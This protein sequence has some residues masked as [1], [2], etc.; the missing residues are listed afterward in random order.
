[1]PPLHTK[2]LNAFSR[3]IAAGIREENVTKIRLSTENY[4]ALLQSL[5]ITSSMIRD[6]SSA[7]KEY[8]GR[9]CVE[10]ASVNGFSLEITFDKSDI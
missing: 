2:I 10:D 4:I 9:P 3:L 8:L 1:M 5:P 6:D 7:L